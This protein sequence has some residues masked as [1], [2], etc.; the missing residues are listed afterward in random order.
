[1][2]FWRFTTFLLLCGTLRA[3]GLR[4]LKAA[5]FRLQGQSPIKARVELSLWQRKKNGG[6][7]IITQG[8][9]QTAAEDGPAGIQVRFSPQ[10]LARSANEGMEKVKNAD[11]PTPCMD[12]MKELDARRIWEYLGYASNIL[13]DLEQCRLASEESATLDGQ[14]IRRLR[15]TTNPSLPSSIRRLLGKLETDVQIWIALDGTPLNAEINY[16]YKGSRFF[17]GFSGWHKE[18]LVF[19]VHDQRLVVV[20]HDWEENFEGFSMDS[21]EHKIYTLSVG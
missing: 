7:P 1:M 4:D 21:A 16:T 6:D 15:F 3:D 8:E 19:R 2:K 20:K 18:K 13:R 10:I 12:C 5:L 9:C 14:P 17:I 11:R